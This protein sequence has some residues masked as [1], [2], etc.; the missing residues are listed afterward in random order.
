MPAMPAPSGNPLQ[1]LARMLFTRVEGQAEDPITPDQFAI[2]L[3]RLATT[4][5]P[6]TTTAGGRLPA[7]AFTPVTTTL[8]PTITTG[9]RSPMEGFDFGKIASG[10]LSTAKYR[11]A[12][13]A[14]RY[15]LSGVNDEAGAEA[16]L[17]NMVPDLEAAGV[18][19][20][21]IAGSRLTLRG[22]RGELCV[23]VIRWNGD[24]G[25]PAF[26]WAESQGA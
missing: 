16:V 11:F 15:D 19:V 4:S 20:V 5:A 10:D 21:A 8:R 7:S 18:P 14:W 22:D 12:R 6:V 2:F 17:K 26:Q 9:P 1:D 25:A 13:V 24:G 23:D 3:G